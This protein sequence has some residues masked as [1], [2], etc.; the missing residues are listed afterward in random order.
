MILVTLTV[1]PFI[2]LRINVPA[3]HLGFWRRAV[4]CGHV[5]RP[6]AVQHVPPLWYTEGHQ[7]GG[8]AP[9]LRRAEIRSHKC[10]SHR[11]PWVLLTCTLF[12]T[13]VGLTLFP[14]PQVY[15]HLHGHTEHLHEAGNDSCQR[16]R[17][18]EEVNSLSLIWL[19]PQ[20]LFTFFLQ[21]SSTKACFITS[22]TWQVFSYSNKTHLNW[23]INMC[24]V[25]E[26]RRG[27]C[28]EIK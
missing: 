25:S 23:W 10:V 3:A 26:Q 24:F 21:Q 6:V 13:G 28:C 5:W 2:C 12:V 27:L 15:G 1:N 18:Q 9:S 11:W 16:W 20:F 19:K 8:D 7:E 17:Q 14:I 22:S 4:L